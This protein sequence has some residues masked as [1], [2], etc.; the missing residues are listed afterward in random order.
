M[1]GICSSVAPESTT[2]EPQKHATGSQLRSRNLDGI[3]V[4]WSGAEVPEGPLKEALFGFDE[5]NAASYPWPIDSFFPV[6]P[7]IF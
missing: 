7:R 3:L 5:E 2:T 6:H 1:L 4:G